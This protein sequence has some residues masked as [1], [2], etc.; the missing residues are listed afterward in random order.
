MRF[1]DFQNS[2]SNLFF[3]KIKKG[4]TVVEATGRGLLMFLENKI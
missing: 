1:L 3:K 2:F 4:S